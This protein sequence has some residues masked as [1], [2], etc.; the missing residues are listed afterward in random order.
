MKAKKTE[1]PAISAIQEL[2]SK[3]DYSMIKPFL[4]ML[5]SNSTK[6]SEQKQDD[7][8]DKPPAIPDPNAQPEDDP[9]YQGLWD[10]IRQAEADIGMDF[11]RRRQRPLDEE[12]LGNEEGT[13][14]RAIRE[15]HIEDGGMHGWL[16]L[17]GVGDVSHRAF[18]TQR[19]GV[20][21]HVLQC[22]EEFCINVI[23]STYVED[24]ASYDFEEHMNKMRRMAILEAMQRCQPTGCSVP[25]F[26]RILSSPHWGCRESREDEPDGEFVAHCAY[27]Y[28]FICTGD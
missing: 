18:T 22:N 9:V 5:Q 25:V 14:G 27:A 7:P 26:R 13:Y 6:Q 8:E 23:Y 2:L 20:G 11:S 4:W 28:T 12:D 19:T 1:H 15:E 21:R 10:R 24:C 3:Q 17:V 16:T